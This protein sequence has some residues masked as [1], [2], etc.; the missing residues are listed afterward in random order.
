MFIWASFSPKVINV[1]TPNTHQSF[2]LSS[3]FNSVSQHKPIVSLDPPDLPG[4]LPR[5]TLKAL[6][7][8]KKKKSSCV[9]LRVW[10]LNFSR[11]FSDDTPPFGMIYERVNSGRSAVHSLWCLQASKWTR[12]TL[13][14]AGGAT[15]AHPCPRCLVPHPRCQDPDSAYLCLGVSA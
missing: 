5:H 7:W 4:E 8:K 10:L 11:T 2:L 6:K 15:V 1:F 3:T 12:D 14:T 9:W 13:N